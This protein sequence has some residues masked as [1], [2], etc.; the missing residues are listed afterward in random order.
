MERA[1]LKRAVEGLVHPR[2]QCR[3]VVSALPCTP[4]QYFQLMLHLL[5]HSTAVLNRHLCPI[6]EPDRM[7]QAGTI[8]QG[9]AGTM[10]RR[11]IS[12]P[13]H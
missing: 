13:W 6:D 2:H 8:L 11:L 10:R 1:L 4:L 7:F 12:N 9:Q 5:D 3:M